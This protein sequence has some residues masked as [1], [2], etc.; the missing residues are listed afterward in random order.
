MAIPLEDNFADVIGKAQ[1]GLQISDSELSQR[2]G[3][4]ASSLKALRDGAFDEDA[5]RT[6]APLLK[7][8]AGA[9][10]D[11]GLNRWQPQP[12]ELAGLAGFNTPFDDMKV[13]SYLVW[14]AE[15]KQAVIFDTGSDCSWML[16]MLHA[17]R[18]SLAFILLT[19]THGDH[20]YD[21]DRIIEKTGAR[22]YVSEREPMSGVESFEAGKVFE[23]GGLRIETRQTWGHSRGGI[24]YVVRGLAQPVAVV[25]D[26]LFA[27]SMGGGMVS[28]ADALRT[29]REEIFTLPYETII[30]PGHGPMT[31]VAEEKI[32]NPFFA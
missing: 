18:L 29:N 22:A 12:V 10:V 5:V 11:L 3:I 15:S 1:R 21:L 32:H 14:D 4:S 23:A 31:T 28:Y 6:I 24:T 7:L 16:D 20:V 25:G 2:S 27:G 17:H 30:C 26:A 19:H 8:N 9:L 13:N